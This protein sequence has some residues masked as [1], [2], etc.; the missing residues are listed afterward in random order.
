[1][2]EIRDVTE[3]DFDA[4]FE[5]LDA[6]SRA[7]FGISQQDRKHLRQR[8][9]LPGGERWVAVVDGTVVGYVMLDEAHEI[10][11]AAVEPEVG[12]A[13]FAH[14]EDAARERGFAHLAVAAVPEDEPLYTAVQRNGYTLEREI[15]RMWRPLNGT[16]PEP[17]WPD[18]V[19]VRTYED[20][21]GERVHALLDDEYGGW[22]PNY[23]ALSHEGW[24]AF[25][26][27]HDEFDPALWY[28]VERD[29]ELVACALHW[30]ESRGRG[31]VKDI[32][33]RNAER[34]RGIAKALLYRGFRAYA[35]RGVERVGLKVDST[36]PTGAPQLYERLGFE[37]DQRLGIWQKRL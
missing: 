23:V 26:T 3:A 25:M 18:G 29:G 31:W 9:E 32:V 5:L 2:P 19:T 36:N 17:V 10:A 27:G 20:A 15:L 14:V 30:K 1:M 7:A 21:D 24:L 37:T 28:V 6:R 34:G 22:D 35:D 4:V 13:L 12:D 11:H 16:L 8:W 33:V